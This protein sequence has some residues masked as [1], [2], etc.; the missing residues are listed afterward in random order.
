[1]IGISN[2]YAHAGNAYRSQAAET[3]SPAQLVI[4]LYDGAIGAVAKAE[5][6]LRH[7]HGA[8]GNATSPAGSPMPRSGR[9]HPASASEPADA[10]PTEIAH[11]ELGRCQDIV[12]ELLLALDYERGGEIAPAL[13]A[14]YDFCLDRLATANI[15]KDAAP[16]VDV[17]RSLTSLRDAW[18]HVAKQEAGAA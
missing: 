11:R 16:L 15:T 7:P 13:A 2:G 5:R 6:A 17:T 12:T 3:A 9:S 4:M 8:G 14:I 10:A 1:M 18:S